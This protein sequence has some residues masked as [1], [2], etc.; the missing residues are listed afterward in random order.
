MLEQQRRLAE[1]RQNR[2]HGDDVNENTMDVP[3]TYQKQDTGGKRQHDTRSMTYK[4]GVGEEGLIDTRMVRRS[5][6]I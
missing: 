2:V 6:P 3:R 1:I 4:A 5:T